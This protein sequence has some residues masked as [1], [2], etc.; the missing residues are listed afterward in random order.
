ML[1]HWIL[2]GLITIEESF[3]A[4]DAFEKGKIPGNDGMP[5]EFHRTFWSSVGE[6]M[7]NTFNF[8]FDSGEMS[9]S[10]KEAI[11]TFID[12]KCNDR[13]YL[14]NWTPISSV[15]ADSKLASK[16]SQHNQKGSS[17]NNPPQLIRFYRG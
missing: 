17:S 9:S 2:E 5:S 4:L 1:K 3:K 8:S 15:N 11:I 16:V 6:L 13:M 14:E 10:Q 7:F 12:K